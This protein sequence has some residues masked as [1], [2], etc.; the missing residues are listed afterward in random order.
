MCACIADWPKLIQNIHA[1][2]SP[3]GWAEFQD[4]DLEYYSD[5]GSL[6]E[7]HDVMV[8]DR[9][10]LS[11][12]GK[13]GREVSPGPR[14]EAWVRDAG[15]RGVLHRKFKFPIGSW[16]RDPVLK[17]VGL[18]NLMQIENGLEA[19]TLRLFTGML[20]WQPEEAEALLAK[21]RKDLRDKSIHA[22]VN[23]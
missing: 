10:F 19:F 12:A 3:G 22:Y 15:F 7:E 4:F 14:F 1:N 20:G 16:P 2:L 18:Y 8:W 17:E 9:L 5:D 21:V 13:T 23:L 11:A 6:K